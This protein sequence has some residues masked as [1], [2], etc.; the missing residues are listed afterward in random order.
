M[1]GRFLSWAELVRRV[2][3]ILDAQ[4]NL[5]DRYG[6]FPIVT[7]DGKADSTAGEDVGMEESFRKFACER[8]KHK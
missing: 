3:E 6:G 1:V 2:E 4:K 8:L 7:K 5:L